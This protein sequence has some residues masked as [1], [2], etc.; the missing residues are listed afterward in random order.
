MTF[1][2]TYSAGW[3]GPCV[4]NKY[5]L[6]LDGGGVLFV[7][8]EPMP[9]KVIKIKRHSISAPAPA[10][11]AAG[12]GNQQQAKRKPQGGPPVALFVVI[13]FV[14]VLLIGLGV[15]ISSSSRS[16]PPRPVQSPTSQRQS[17]KKFRRPVGEMRDYML[18]HQEPELLKAR[19]ARKAGKRPKR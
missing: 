16:A 17:A 13:G 6:A 2:D 8:K 12:Y 19:K 7:S 5:G 14:V 11:P 3:I 15:A 1:A 9:P 18:S 4:Q 10:T